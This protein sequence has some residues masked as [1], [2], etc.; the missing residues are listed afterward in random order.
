MKKYIAVIDPKAH[1]YNGFKFRELEA[2]DIFEAMNE[3]ENLMD[4]TTYLVRI[5]E[6]TGKAVKTEGVSKTCFAEVLTNRGNGWH[7][8]DQKH[9]ES[10][11]IWAQ[12]KAKYGTW[13]EIINI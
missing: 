5:A 7:V 2:K 3:A 13:Y 11:A 4:E 6:K 1:C 10:A 12:N 8:T 9:G